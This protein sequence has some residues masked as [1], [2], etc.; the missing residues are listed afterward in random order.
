[1]HV[2]GK[3]SNPV[4]IIRKGDVPKLFTAEF[5]HLFGLWRLFHYKLTPP[6]GLTW[7]EIR[8]DYLDTITYMQNHYEVHF[9]YELR[10]Y[11]EIAEIKAYIKA[12]FDSLKKSKR[13]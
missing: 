12:Y 11:Q 8:P 6:G 9:S 3:G 7:N 10:M 13:R 1:M 5:H 2:I 4:L